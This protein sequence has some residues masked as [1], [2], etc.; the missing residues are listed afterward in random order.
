MIPD[1]YDAFRNYEAEQERVERLHKRFD[2][3][4]NIEPEELPFIE[5]PN[6][7]GTHKELYLGGTYG[8]R[9]N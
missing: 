3:E 5:V 4:E 9:R 6:D 7:Y 8:K 2:A 1:N